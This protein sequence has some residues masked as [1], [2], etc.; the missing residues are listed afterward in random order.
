MP[1]L[2]GKATHKDFLT[3]FDAH[4]RATRTEHVPT[5]PDS[6]D[7]VDVQEYPKAVVSLDEDGKPLA[8]PVV[9]RDA[10]HEAEL[11]EK[12]EE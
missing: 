7:K 4:E 8:D 10:D 9:A 1:E 2:D 11:A 5:G 12:A 3:P 6:P